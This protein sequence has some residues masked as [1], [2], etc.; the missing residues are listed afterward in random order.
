[1]YDYTPSSSLFKVNEKLI[2]FYSQ[3]AFE[4]NTGNLLQNHITLKRSVFLKFGCATYM[5]L[6]TL[7]P[8]S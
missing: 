1:M 6:R 3:L 4:K 8:L 5:F 7:N 2:R